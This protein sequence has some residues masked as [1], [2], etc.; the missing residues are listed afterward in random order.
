M[1]T[2]NQKFDV[3]IV[4]A[5]VVGASMASYLAKHGKSV[6]VI[7]KSFKEQ[8]GIIGE[9][10]QPGGVAQLEKLGLAHVLDQFESPKVKGYALFLDDQHFKIDYP[11]EN[12]KEI[13]GRGFYNSRFVKKLRDEFTQFPNICS[14]EATVNALIENEDKSEILGVKYLVKGED[15]ARE[16]KAA[17]TI[18][19]DGA[20][21]SFRNELTDAKKEI[22]SFFIGLILK[23]CKPP[24]E[25]YGHVIVAK[26]SPVLVYPISDTEYRILIDFPGQQAPRKGDELNNFLKNVIAPQLPEGIL[27]SF[28]AAVEEG[29]FKSMPNHLLPALPKLK[30]GGVL[31]GDSLNMRHPLTG[32]GMTVALTDVNLLGSKL[33][34]IENFDDKEVLVEKISEF[35][36]ERHKHVANLN[37][38]ADALYRVLSHEDLRN[39]CY[40]YLKRGGEYAEEPIAIL[41]A[42]TTNRILLLKHFISV[43]L[44]GAKNL[45]APVPTPD[46]I[47]R[48][49]KMIQDSTK[50][51][52]PL[53]MNNDPDI[54]TKSALRLSELVYR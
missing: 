32:S 15:E 46:R 10:M 28:Y 47:A 21:S 14:I 52:R 38:L 35:Y 43:A 27:P 19:C 17:L 34:A 23:N 40:D 53:I 25:N 3:C 22:N 36:K 45:V 44:W 37:I 26:P 16:I 42:V 5:G 11:N 33:A 29:H 7:E 12:G 51:I 9:L 8:E 48:A 49:N 6:C 18:V 41:S 2:I 24:F 39:A 13:R 54:V 31:I 20:F 30:K 4:G 1:E 50:I